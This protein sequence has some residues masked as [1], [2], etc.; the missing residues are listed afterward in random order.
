MNSLFPPKK[1][2]DKRG[3]QKKLRKKHRKNGKKNTTVPEKLK[4]ENIIS[5]TMSPYAYPKETR[6]QQMSKDFQVLLPVK[7]VEN[8]LVINY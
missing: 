2:R 4:Q 8:S 5:E 3:S 7:A 1:E 6:I